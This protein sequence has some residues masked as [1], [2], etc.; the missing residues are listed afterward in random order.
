MSIIGQ[1]VRTRQGDFVVDP[2]DEFIGQRML[3]E[4][5]YAPNELALLASQITPESDVLIC[6]A[7][8]G[9]FAVP[10]SKW[11]KALVAVEANPVTYQILLMNLKLNECHNVEAH[12]GAVNDTDDKPLQFLC[13][14]HNSGG[15]K[16]VPLHARAD[17]TYDNPMEVS[18]PT[19]VLDK[20]C[21]GWQFDLMHLDIE[22]SEVFALRGA[23]TLLPHVKYLSV[24]FISHHLT[25]VAGV[26]VE[27][28]LAPIRPHFNKMLLPGDTGLQRP[29]VVIEADDWQ[30]LLQNIVNADVGVEELIFWRA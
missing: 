10:L 23:Q 4:G 22:G 9:A 3:R 27:E 6:G 14:T 19:L 16:R 25:H 28:W 1:V 21:A 30:E 29:H 5:A 15:S 24:E 7:H 12:F 2:E 18:V 26:T 20:L 11:C 8:V 17:Y 13:G